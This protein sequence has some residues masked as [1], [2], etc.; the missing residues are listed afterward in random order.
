[1]ELRRM[2]EAAEKQEK[3]N[4]GTTARKPKKRKA[5]KRKATTRK[6]KEKG[7]QRK[8]MVWCVFNGSMKEEGRFPYDQKEAAEAKLEQLRSKSKK[9]Y[10]LQ[11][12]KEVMG[13]VAPPSIDSIPT[14][15]D[16]D[17]DTDNGADISDDDDTDTD[18]DDE[19]MEDMDDDFDDDDD[20]DDSESDN[21]DD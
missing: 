1:M 14:D 8:R 4:R 6:S 17:T 18:S 7:L 11:P 9:L 3:E 19:S 20:G 16:L 2:A 5:T 15:D 21:D 13:D 12:V 10:F